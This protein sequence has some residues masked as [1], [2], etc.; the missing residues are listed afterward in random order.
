MRALNGRFARPGAGGTPT[1]LVVA[2]A[3][4]VMPTLQEQISEKFLRKL[5]ES[6]EV[7]A[8]KIDKLKVLLSNNKRAKAEDFV[9]IFTTPVGE[10]L[11]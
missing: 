9:K 6:D 11:K 10:D 4:V 8:A 1:E 5:A 3:E 7:D 2:D